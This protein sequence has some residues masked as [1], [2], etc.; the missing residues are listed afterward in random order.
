[1]YDRVVCKESR[2]W[3]AQNNTT[4]ARTEIMNLAAKEEI[5]KNSSRFLMIIT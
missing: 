2:H 1:M 5:K 4:E 3:T